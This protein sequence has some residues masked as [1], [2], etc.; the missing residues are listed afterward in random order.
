M[1]RAGK[2]K[3]ALNDL[4]ASFEF[5]P[6]DKKHYKDLKK[7]HFL[8]L[9]LTYLAPLLILSVYFYFQ[10]SSIESEGEKLHLKTIAENQANTFD[11]FLTERLINLS[12]LIKD[13]SLKFPPSYDQIMN[14]LKQLQKSSDTF[15]DIGYFDSSG[16][17]VS[18]AGPYPSLGKR[19]YSQEDWFVSL[20]RKDEGYVITDIYL[21]FRQK[22]HFTIAVSEGKDGDFAIL[23][24]TLDPAKIYDYIRSLEGANEVI[25]SIV[26]QEGFYQIVT[27]HLGTPL[28]SSSIVPPRSSNLGIEK[29]TIEG[30]KI[31]YAYSW[32]RN[33]DWA[34]IVQQ[35]NQDE[36]PFLSDLRE[37]IIGVSAMLVI[38]TL[39]IILLRSKKLVEIQI[40]T[41]RT[42][43][44]LEHAAKLASVG[45][46]AAGIAHEINNPLAAINE[47]AGLIKDLTGPEFGKNISCEEIKPHL[48]SIQ[49]SVFRCR[50]IIRKLMGFVRK[51]DLSLGTCDM[52]SLLDDVLDGL[53]IREMRASN[54]EVVKHYSYE[55]PNINTD[56]NQLQQVI[57]NIINNCID[58]FDNR[59][60]KITIT[61]YRDDKYINIA[62]ADTGKGM[63]P[64]VL[65]KIFMPF[66]TTKEVG[67]GT[68]LGLSVSYGIVKNLGGKIEVESAPDEGST[69]TIK[70]PIV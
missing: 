57:L 14:Y 26:N 18:Y 64:E 52:N 27:S 50:D 7:R 34:L 30:Q 1:G 9:S 2:M 53:I 22:P 41:D 48:D 51:T 33:A 11:L 62:I 20:L 67:K 23:R 43:A 68:G 42:R 17:Q 28:T 45:E 65:S 56:G 36:T 60:G 4:E 70:L 5:L 44:Q 3:P 39:I 37:R 10:Y 49:E 24:A 66:F 31:T 19:N 35:A 54:I 63:T 58:A 6:Y 55:L 29:I 13:P 61:T 15:V 69:F 38:I 25:T 46:L 32:L 40:E 16:V 47:E 21:G 8:R 59:P 12:N